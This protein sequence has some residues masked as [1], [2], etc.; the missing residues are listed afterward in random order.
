MNKRNWSEEVSYQFFMR[1]KSHILAENVRRALA[2]L[3]LRGRSY[4]VFTARRIIDGTTRT[5]PDV[6][7][8]R[9]GKDPNVLILSHENGE[10]AFDTLREVVVG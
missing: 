2:V 6:I 8:A 7:T 3:I 4:Y 10:M 1:F 9:L 5:G